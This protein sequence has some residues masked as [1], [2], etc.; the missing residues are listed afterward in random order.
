M[1]AA[2]MLAAVFTGMVISTQPALNGMLGR[3]LGSSYGAT[4]ISVGVAFVGAVVLALLMGR[5]G[6]TR[7]ALGSVPWYV[8]LAGLAGTVFVA[9]GTV[10]APVTGALVFF[11]CVVAGQLI[12]AMLAD[13]FGAFGL[14]VREISVLRL[15]GLVL[16]IAGALLVQRG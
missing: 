10:I 6:M 14:A 2:Y 15:A 9:G 8:Y 1:I 4:L 13:H 7:A 3:A 12:G 16:V 5:G 11:V